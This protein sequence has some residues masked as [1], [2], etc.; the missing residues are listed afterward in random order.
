MAA[1][2]G[3]QFWKIRS[4]HGR[5]KLFSSSKLLMQAASEYFQWVD[6]H[7]W[8]KKEQTKK[9]TILKDKEGN[10]SIDYVTD[11][12][13]A[14]PYTLSGLCI[15][16][17]VN[18]QY[19]TDFKQGLVP[20]DGAKWTKKNKDFSLVITRIEE[21]IRTQKFEGAAVGAFNANIIAR[22]LGMVEKVESKNQNTNYNYNSVDLSAKDIQDISKA[23]EDDV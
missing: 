6:N 20:R 2:K 19:F 16:L 7:P 18:N 3:N 15:Y 12:P 22:D 21:I 4:K 8:V 5:K 10:Q 23:L 17:D 9:P 11:I 1:P 13:T 14:R